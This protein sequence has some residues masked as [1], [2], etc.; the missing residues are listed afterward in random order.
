MTTDVQSRAKRLR[1]PWYQFLQRAIQSLADANSG[2]QEHVDLTCF[3]SLD[4]SDVQVGHLCELL[5]CNVLRDPLA[6]DVV[7]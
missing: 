1:V 3:N 5:L 7:A 4:I 6:A 2:R